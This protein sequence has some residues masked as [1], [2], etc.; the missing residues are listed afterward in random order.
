MLWTETEVRILAPTSMTMRPQ[1]VI[2]NFE[3]LEMYRADLKV[4]GHF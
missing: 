2:E 3:N 4:M 1:K